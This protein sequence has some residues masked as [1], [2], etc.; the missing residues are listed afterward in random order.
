MGSEFFKQ[1]FLSRFTV[2]GSNETFAGIK[3]GAD[4]D[5]DM[6]T[7]KG[8]R[9]DELIQVNL[10]NHLDQHVPGDCGFLI[11]LDSLASSLMSLAL[12]KGENFETG[13]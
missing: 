10:T 2:S 3:Q 5:F 6:D 4:H 9:V 11:C 12:A 8:R 13:E 7:S 1:P